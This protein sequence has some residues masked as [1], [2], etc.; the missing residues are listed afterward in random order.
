MRT[1]RSAIKLSALLIAGVLSAD[2]AAAEITPANRAR[3]DRIEQSLKADVPRVL[4]LD[5]NIS[6]GAQPK[7]TA[8]ASAAANGF[9]SVLSLRTASEG[10]DLSRERSH[11][12]KDWH[13]LLKY[14]G[15][16]KRAALGAGR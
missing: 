16:L 11:R 15:S 4:C 13:A 6:T 12:R 14:P 9:R 8:Y 10:I 5:E 3:L 1:P 7:E 2:V